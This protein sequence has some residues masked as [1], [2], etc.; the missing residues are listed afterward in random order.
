M[1]GLRTKQFGSDLDR[2]PRAQEDGVLVERNTFL[3]FDQVS[4]ASTAATRSDVRGKARSLSPTYRYPRRKS[5]VVPFRM[6][7]KKDEIRQVLSAP[8]RLGG[9]PTW[10]T[11]LSLAQLGDEDMSDFDCDLECFE[12]DLSEDDASPTFPDTPSLTPRSK[13]EAPEVEQRVEEPAY[14]HQPVYMV[15]LP[16]QQLLPWVPYAPEPVAPRTRMLAEHVHSSMIE[17]GLT[18]AHLV[19][20]VFTEVWEELCGVAPSKSSRAQV[21]RFRLALEA[22]PDLFECF[23]A[24]MGIHVP[25]GRDDKMVRVVRKD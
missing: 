13:F 8:T 12:V 5:V 22:C 14:W 23:N 7:D 10:G 16:V 18:G 20:D 2:K 6:P 21:E 1:L 11:Q 25:N 17:K 19:V 3:H 4:E 15:P 9:Q 24:S